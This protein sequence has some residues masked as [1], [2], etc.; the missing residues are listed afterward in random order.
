MRRLPTASYHG[1]RRAPLPLVL[2]PPPLSVC[3]ASSLLSPATNPRS[4]AST[5]TPPSF[6]APPEPPPLRTAPSLT[7]MNL[8]A[9]AQPSVH[10]HHRQASSLPEP[11][12]KPMHRHRPER[13]PPPPP[14]PSFGP[15]AQPTSP[16]SSTTTTSSTAVVIADLDELLLMALPPLASE[17]RSFPY[18][19][20]QQ[21]WEKVERVPRRDPERWR[22]DALDNVVFRKLVGC[23]GS[24]CHD[25]N[26]IVPY[27]KEAF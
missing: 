18:V 20:K 17:P 5:A 7:A 21:C 11:P 26:H 24:L 3:H 16:C 1:L 4:P 9:P 8:D 25:Y 2:S 15:T 12:S 27:S 22:R 14:P 19:V 23:P 6:E 10:R 13:P